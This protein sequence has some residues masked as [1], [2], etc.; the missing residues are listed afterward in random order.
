MEMPPQKLSSVTDQ[1][2]WRR[3]L[4]HDRTIAETILLENGEICPFFVLY[5]Q[6]RVTQLVVSI[7]SKEQKRELYS[8]LTLVGIALE[9]DG[10]TFFTEARE[11][12]D[13][14]RR[15]VI[16]GFGIYRDASGDRQCLLDG[17]AIEGKSDGLIDALRWKTYPTPTGNIINIIPE[18]EPTTEEMARAKVLFNRTCDER[19][20]TLNIR[21]VPRVSEPST[22]LC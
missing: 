6:D 16:F 4:N 17:T 9:I 18:V 13:S 10:F 12:R 8:F 1:E 14:G 2:L 5:K 21:E 11:S 20:K 3:R 7:T 22:A 15:K 19:L